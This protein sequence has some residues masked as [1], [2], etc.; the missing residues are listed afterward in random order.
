MTVTDST[1]ADNSAFQGGGVSNNYG[2]TLTIV[3]STLA[4]N[5]ANQYGGA[6]DNVGTLTTISSTIAYNTV[7]AGGIGAGIDA[8]GG[9]TIL[10]DSIVVLNTNGT[11]STAPADDISGSVSSS[12]AYN[13]IGV[14]GLNNG[15]NGNL[16]GVT[17]PGLAAGLAANGGPTET[18]A[19]LAGSPALGAGSA[20]ITGVSVPSTDQ[21]GTNRPAS[22]FDIGAYQSA[23]VFVT[24]STSSTKAATVSQAAPTT[25]VTNA[26]AAPSIVSTPSPFGGRRLSSKGHRKAAKSPAHAAVHHAI[27]TVSVKPQTTPSVRIARHR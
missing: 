2:G 19:L 7:T 18:I 15:V 21:T 5:S 23:F 1:I 14:G 3:D 12:S 13:M 10:Y 25:V 26:L 11:A 9:T 6:I 22:K 16:V 20:S 27:R 4:N 17:K 8:Y 24:S